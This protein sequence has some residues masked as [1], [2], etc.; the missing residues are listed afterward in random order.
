M[1][2]SL[3]LADEIIVASGVEAEG[4]R[5][6]SGREPVLVHHSVHVPES[7]AGWA[8]RRNLVFSL[9]HM[10][11]EASIMRKRFDNV[12]RAAAIVVKHVPDVEFVLAGAKGPGFRLDRLAEECGVAHLVRFPGSISNEDRQGY[13]RLARVLAQ[14]ALWEGFGLVQAEA[15][16]EGLPVVTSP[17]GAVPEVVGDTALFCDRDSPG[18]I[19]E[20]IVVA[21]TDRGKWEEMSLGGSAR[22]R[23]MF[24]YPRRRRRI[25]EVIYTMTGGGNVGRK[26]EGCG[27][28]R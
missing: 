18:D 25:G 7:L 28:S 4:V 10:S 3:R 2:L 8:A 23:E 22:V 16:A 20:K 13:L 9:G 12:V 6:L 17:S 19:A 27:A 1:R 24:D 26:A 15:M 21:L 11:T 14:P 5:I